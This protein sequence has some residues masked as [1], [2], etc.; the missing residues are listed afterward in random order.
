MDNIENIFP[1]W[2]K[3]KES[4]KNTI[5]NS[6]KKEKYSKG[7]I[8]NKTENTCKGLLAV[9]SGQLRVYILS[10]EGREITLFRVKQGEICV[11]SASCLM[12]S[13][14]FDTLIEAAE[15]TEILIIPST[16]FKQIIEHNPYVELY[17][18][19]ATTEK[20]SDVMWTMQQILFLKI[21]KRIAQFL[22][23]EMINN[24][25]LTL[26]ITHEE[27]AKYIGSA[28]EVVTKVL[29]YLSQENIIELKRGIIKITSKEKLQKFLQM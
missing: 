20:F 21:D 26:H 23:D 27:I 15:N 10:E 28:R 3:L 12:D 5:T 24:N 22:W 8:I 9:L 11:L 14:T 29:K 19:K 4:E 7:M 13:I 16:I 17:L 18:Y 1:F 25:S 2:N 6:I